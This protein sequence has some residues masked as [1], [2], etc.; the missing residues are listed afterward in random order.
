MGY[1][2][3]LNCRGKYAAFR[4]SS[5]PQYPKTMKNSRILTLCLYDMCLFSHKTNVIFSEYIELVKS[6]KIRANHTGKYT[7]FQISSIAQY[8]KTMKNSYILTLCLCDLCL[9]PIEL[10]L[11]FLGVDRTCQEL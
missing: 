6:C 10:T 3:M 8:R 2:M 11:F 5:I 1:K 9:F 7:V 4:I